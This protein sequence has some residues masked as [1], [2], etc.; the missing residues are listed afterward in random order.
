MP[1]SFLYQLGLFIQKLINKADILAI[2]TVKL[3]VIWEGTIL[4][5]NHMARTNQLNLLMIGSLMVFVR[6]LPV[7]LELSY[8]DSCPKARMKSLHTPQSP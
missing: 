2:M 8:S 6:L 4:S 3:R 7:F 5:S 1:L